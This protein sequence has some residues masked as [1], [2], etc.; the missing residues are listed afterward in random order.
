MADSRLELWP[1]EISEA[2]SL[3]KSQKPIENDFDN[4]GVSLAVFFAL[5]P[6]SLTICSRAHQQIINYKS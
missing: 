6:L 4:F 5:T 1:L 2:F 3:N